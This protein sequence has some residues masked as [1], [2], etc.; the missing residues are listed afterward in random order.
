MRPV[1]MIGS[2]DDQIMGGQ[3][4]DG[5]M[6]GW[7]GFGL[8]WMLFWIA[9]LVLVVVGIPR[10]LQGRPGGAMDSREESPMEILKR[11]YAQGEIDREEFDAKKRDLGYG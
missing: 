7:W 9:L 1:G 11:R 3:W 2:L 8:L 10:W 6:D 5:M 4:M